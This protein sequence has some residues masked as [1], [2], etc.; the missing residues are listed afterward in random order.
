MS[1]FHSALWKIL[2]ALMSEGICTPAEKTSHLILSLAKSRSFLL[3][4]KLPDNTTR[5]EI[6]AITIS[7]HE[8][9]FLNGVIKANLK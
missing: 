1:H 8:P 9:A 3:F 5:I 4:H 6:G 7:D 2:K